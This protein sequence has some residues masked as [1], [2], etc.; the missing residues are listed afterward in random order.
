[1]PDI[2]TE[3]MWKKWMTALQGVVLPGG[4]GKGQQF[5]AA[6]TTLNIDLVNDDP[7][8]SRYNIYN[9]GDVVPAEGP[10]YA[11]ASGLEVSYQLFLDNIDLGGSYNPNLDSQINIAKQKRD[12]AQTQYNATFKAAWDQFKVYQGV[13][14][15]A[16][17]ETWASQ[18]YPSYYSDLDALNGATTAYEDLLRMKYGAGYEVVNSAKSKVGVLGAQSMNQNA[19]NMQVKL[20][21]IPPAGSTPDLAGQKPAQGDLVA[22]YRPSYYLSAF[23]QKYQDWQTNSIHNIVGATIS[24]SEASETYNYD[25]FG[26]DASIK[27]NWISEFFRI[28]AGGSTSGSKE[29]I[30]TKSK[31]FELSIDFT[32]IGAFPISPGVWWDN[33]SL[34]SNFHNKLLNGAPDF[35]GENGSLARVTYQIVVGFEPAIRLKMHADNYNSIKTEWQA[36][37]NLSIG[38]GPFRIGKAEVSVYGE[39]E[40]IQWDDANATVKIG[41]VKSAMP[42][43]LG[44]ISQRQGL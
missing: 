35:F 42:V 29:K 19:Y 34:V 8:I 3:Y 23:T 40:N 41:P 6:S 32:G 37:A 7:C 44:V 25:K 14:P 12:S 16:T 24:I 22:I 36:D 28:F 2:E 31:D 17:F 9:I 11:P 1:M 39:K 10:A 26:W 20:S 33:G 4:I 13:F 5:S 21:T 43:L 30:D 27:G 38:I 18:N 15:G